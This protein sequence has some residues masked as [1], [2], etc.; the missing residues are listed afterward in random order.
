MVALGAPRPSA[1]GDQKKKKRKRKKKK[2]NASVFTFLKCG[3]LK[4][5]KKLQINMINQV[6]WLIK[7]SFLIIMR[8]KFTFSPFQSGNS[9][10]KVP[11]QLSSFSAHFSCPALDGDMG[12]GPEG[13]P[14]LVSEA[15][16]SPGQTETSQDPESRAKS[17]PSGGWGDIWKERLSYWKHHK[18]VTS[19][20]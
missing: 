8:R 9:F 4:K 16:M 15:T 2:E 20:V 17:H 18:L 3:K 12:R 10:M 11:F 14:A 1:S 5:N 6:P 7:Y 13:H 19:E